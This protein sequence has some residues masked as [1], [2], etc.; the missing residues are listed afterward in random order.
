MDLT[1]FK[2]MDRNQLQNYLEFLLWHY[3]V[4]DA[5]WFLRV[6]ERYD[7]PAAEAI[8][9]EVWAKVS[10]MAAKDLLG[11]FA[12]EETG[13]AG[14]V[15]A[16]KLFPWSMLVGYR[17]EQKPDRV[18]LSVPD[19]P[20]QRARLRR[21]LGE[22]VCKDMHRREFEEFARVVDGRIRVA[23]DFAP[24]DPHPAEMFCRWRFWLEEVERPGE[25]G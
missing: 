15:K 13:L 8:N 17:I 18:I 21:G 1:M 7:Q 6:A 24:P 9:E 5:F 23:C 22:Y 14:F 4:V 12:I 2:D 25:I 20:T 3:R 16:L 11:R 10:A 19:C